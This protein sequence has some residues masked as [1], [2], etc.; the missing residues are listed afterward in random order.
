MSTK[1]SE[2]EQEEAQEEERR[3]AFTDQVTTCLRRDRP[4][5]RR[6]RTATVLASEE[7]A[8]VHAG[9]VVCDPG[10]AG[11]HEDRL[12][13][14]R[15]DAFGVDGPE[16]GVGPEAGAALLHLVLRRETPAEK[17]GFVELLAAAIEQAR[18][19]GLIEER[20]ETGA[21]DSTGYEAGRTSSYY[22]KR[23]GFKKS[24]YPKLTVVCDTKSYLYL[25][26]V[27]DRGP[28]PDDREFQRAVREAFW[29]Q[30]FDELL[31]DAGYDSEWNHWYLREHLGVRSVIPPTRGRPTQKLP[32]QKY[33]RMMVS[34][35]PKDR[36]GKR[37]HVESCF[38][39]D[40]R[41]FGWQISA[42]GYWPQNRQL[43][44]RVLVHNIA[45]LLC[46]IHLF[47]RAALIPFLKSCD[48]LLV[49]KFGCFFAPQAVFPNLRKRPVGLG[50]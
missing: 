43:L 24:R 5:S 11:L 2:E 17:R 7:S 16:G 28:L 21:I 36:Y 4:E 8:Q 41:R 45:I 30:P 48:G 15:G 37:W 10:I 23:C 40:K 50:P 19:R 38:S 29:L 6:S 39:Q 47:N 18:E 26:A 33:R 31:A 49:R 35:F 20:T 1:R 32:E 42:A 44:L 22:G 46:P 3:D 12:P 27:V 14:G 25:S 13:R 9:P 34:Q